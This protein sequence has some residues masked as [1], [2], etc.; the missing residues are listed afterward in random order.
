MY[1]TETLSEAG[2][3]YVVMIDKGQHILYNKHNGQYEIWATNKNYAGY[4]LSWRNTNL[5]FC[6]SIPY[7]SRIQSR[8]GTFIPQ[9]NSYSLTTQV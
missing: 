8:R 9:A 7:G 5:E 2:M 1:K 4:T 6:S 3:L